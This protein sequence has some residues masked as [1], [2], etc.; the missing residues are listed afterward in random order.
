MAGCSWWSTGQLVKTF[1]VPEPEHRCVASMS[2]TSNRN[3][4]RKAEACLPTRSPPARLAP[5]RPGASRAGSGSGRLGASNS[6]VPVAAREIQCPKDQSYA[7][8]LA[9]AATWRTAAWVISPGYGRGKRGETTPAADLAARASLWLRAGEPAS[10]EQIGQGN[11]STAYPRGNS[12]Q[13][14]SDDRSGRAWMAPGDEL[15]G[16]AGR[17]AAGTL[18]R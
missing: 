8:C 4:S 2:K 16:P 10:S 13:H 17:R 9:G 18:E 5:A 11:V 15:R 3:L 6:D 1:H 12:S 7:A 14:D